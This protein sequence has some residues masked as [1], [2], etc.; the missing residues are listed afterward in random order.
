MINAG[1]VLSLLATLLIIIF[2]ELLFK[3]TEQSL[4][5][6][7]SAIIGTAMFYGRITRKYKLVISA[8]LSDKITSPEEIPGLYP[9]KLPEL[10]KRNIIALTA[11][12][13]ILLI[14]ILSLYNNGIATL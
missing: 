9:I 4:F 10:T 2:R 8:I 3:V 1:F 6:S 5:L 13:L 11:L 12:L 7:L 14:I